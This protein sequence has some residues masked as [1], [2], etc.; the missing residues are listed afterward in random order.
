MAG[1]VHRSVRAIVLACMAGGVDAR[2]RAAAMTLLT[3]IKAAALLRP[4]TISP[5]IAPLLLFV[6]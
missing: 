1:T 2:G 6:Y 5:K 4:K 3:T